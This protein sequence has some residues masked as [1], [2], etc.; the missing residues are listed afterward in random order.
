MFVPEDC[1][2]AGHRSTL[3]GSVKNR[4]NF[5]FTHMKLNHLAKTYP[6]PKGWFDNFAVE[7]QIRDVKVTQ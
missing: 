6:I 4:N 7:L 3:K 2:V 5:P 1:F